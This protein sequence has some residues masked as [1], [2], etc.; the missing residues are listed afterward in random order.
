[1]CKKP[2]QYGFR[3]SENDVTMMEKCM[4]EMQK[5]NP[6]GK[7]GQ[8]DVMRFALKTL[9]DELTVSEESNNDE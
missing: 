7:I 4:L 8:S 3:P 1:M 9:F 5:L 6:Y 2:S